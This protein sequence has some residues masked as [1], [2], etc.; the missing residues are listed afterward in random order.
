MPKNRSTPYFR[1]VNLDEYQHYSDRSPPWIK[2]H[3]KTLESYDFGCLQDASKA[4]LMLIWLLAS[5][6]KN[7][8]PYDAVWIGNKIQAREPVNLDELQDSGFIEVFENASAL[9]ATSLRDA[10]PEGE[11][12]TETEGEQRRK[13]ACAEPASPPSAPSPVFITI[14]V[15]GSGI[16]E[17][18]ITDAMVT[19]WEPVYPGV[20]VRQQ[21]RHMREWCVSNPAKRKTA[22]GLRRFITAWLAREQDRGGGTGPPT[23]APPQR[24]STGRFWDNLREAA[25][26]TNQ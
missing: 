24:S 11:R 1:V 4:H 5:R 9:Q 6:T 16:G 13:D 19:E 18:E 2:L 15:V 26:E 25:R 3:A 8:L 7:R 10:R 21:L 14:P 20:D 23:R 12:E 22:R 17:A